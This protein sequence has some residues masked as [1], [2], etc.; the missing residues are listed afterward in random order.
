MV[1]ATDKCWLLK[2]SAEIGGHVEEVFFE[3]WTML[4]DNSDGRVSR[5]KGNLCSS[6]EDGR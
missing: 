3:F 2:I 5:P 6:E 1:Q 4:V